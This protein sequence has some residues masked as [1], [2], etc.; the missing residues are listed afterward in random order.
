[1]K[2]PSARRSSVT[3]HSMS[4]SRSGCR[5]PIV[6][7]KNWV[8][9]SKYARRWPTR[10]RRSSSA[11]WCRRFGSSRAVADYSRHDGRVAGRDSRA[12]A[13]PPQC[14]PAPRRPRRQPAAVAK[15][16]RNLYATT[17]ACRASARARSPSTSRRRWRCPPK[18]SPTNGP[19]IHVAGRDQRHRRR[20]RAKSSCRGR[21][22][23]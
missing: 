1:M 16:C 17:P 5:I 14:A 22:L 18:R 23:V 9:R 3:C 10:W 2:R 21:S 11:T 13:G 19:A 6:L 12:H 4:R 20:P 7:T 8:T 15:A